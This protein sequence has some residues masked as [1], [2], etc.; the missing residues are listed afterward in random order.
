MYYLGIDVNKRDS[1]I[2]VLDQ[3]AEIVGEVRVDHAN[4]DD[5]AKQYAGSKAGIEAT[6]NYFT[7]YDTLDEHL[8]VAVTNPFRT[9]AIGHARVKNDRLDA[10]LFAQLRRAELIAES[11]VPP[12][13]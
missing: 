13:Y 6:G 4:L 11:Y 8:D 1:Y 5:F 3:N 7:I 10:K 12:G 2:A 9:K